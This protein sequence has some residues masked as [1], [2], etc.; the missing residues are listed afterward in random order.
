MIDVYPSH[1]AAD[2]E[3]ASRYG[4][5]PCLIRKVGAKPFPLPA[6]VRLNPAAQSRPQVNPFPI[7][8]G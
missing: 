3:A 6:V 8:G 4:R 1:E 5:E 2:E 7:C